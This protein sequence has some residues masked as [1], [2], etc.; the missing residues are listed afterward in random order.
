MTADRVDGES[1]CTD[2]EDP[3]R[4]G[5]LSDDTIGRA[6]HLIREADDVFLIAARQKPDGEIATAHAIQYLT[7][8]REDL[9]S[10]VEEALTP[11]A[12]MNTRRTKVSRH[13]RCP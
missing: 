5:L 10:R 9:L 2:M 4:D 12:T 13:E 11:F 1:H 6:E 8:H 7:T 3:D